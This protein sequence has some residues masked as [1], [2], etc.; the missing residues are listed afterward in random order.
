M[1]KSN[2]IIWIALSVFFMMFSSSIYAA[3]VLNPKKI[4]TGG[5]ILYVDPRIEIGETL[6]V[7]TYNDLLSNILSVYCNGMTPYSSSSTLTRSTSVP[8]AYETGISGVGVIITDLWKGAGTKVPYNTTITEGQLT[9]W[10]NNQNIKLTFVKTGP[11]DT[12]GSTGSKTLVKYTLGGQTVVSIFLQSLTVVQKSCLVDLRHKHQTVDL[13]NPKSNEFTSIGSYAESSERNF[14][15]YINCEA[16]DIPLNISFEPIGS[17]P[18]DGMINID[19]GGASGVVVEILDESR[20]P[21][22][23]STIKTYNSSISTTVIPLVARFKR[24]GDI[25]PGIANAAMTFT[26]TQN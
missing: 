16:P 21:L 23:F 19:S 12:G 17:S 18:G 25:T 6:Y 14:S 3:C 24:V 4:S 20:K 26:I 13:G 1:I 22:K 2:K 7:R 8:E 10:I 11:I 15:I 9:P 5:M